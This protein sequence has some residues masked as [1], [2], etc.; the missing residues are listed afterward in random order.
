LERALPPDI[1]SYPALFDVAQGGIHFYFGIGFF[2]ASVCTMF[3]WHIVHLCSLVYT[4]GLSAL[5][6]QQ[7]F[8]FLP[9]N[10]YLI[11]CIY[12]LFLSLVFVSLSHFF[13][14]QWL[15][16][17]IWASLGTLLS[18]LKD[19]VIRS[20]GVWDRYSFGIPLVFPYYFD[21]LVAFLYHI[22]FLACLVG[23]IRLW[24]VRIW[25]LLL[26][27]VMPCV[28][29]NLGTQMWDFFE[30]GYPF[31]WL[32]MVGTGIDGLLFGFCMY[33]GMVWH[34]RRACPRQSRTEGGS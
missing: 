9:Y 34:Y 20:M 33:A 16:L 21:P 11:G 3:T 18:F 31:S 26:G 32:D 10:Y 17:I 12:A 7:I 8:G 25:N 28:L 2:I 13:R 23:V 24:G 19:A 4:G 15:L 1:R 14:K 5:R 30:K 6:N 22:L 27:M 29:A